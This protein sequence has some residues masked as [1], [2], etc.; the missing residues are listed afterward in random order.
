MDV[1]ELSGPLGPETSFDLEARLTAATTPLR[2]AAVVD[3]RSADDIH[4]SVGSVL[5]RHQRQARRQGGDLR[6]LGPVAAPARRTLD[7]IGLCD[8]THASGR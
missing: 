7:H 2:P 1:I 3:L 8:V 4:P 5:L 6:I